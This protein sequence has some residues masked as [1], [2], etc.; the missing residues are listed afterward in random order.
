MNRPSVE[1]A[2]P[3]WPSAWPSSCANFQLKRPGR[4]L[5]C[6][7]R[8]A[9]PSRPDCGT[10]TSMVFVC[11][12]RLRHRHAVLYFHLASWLSAAKLG[13]FRTACSGIFV[14]HGGI[15]ESRLFAKPLPR[16]QPVRGDCVHPLDDLARQPRF[17][18]LAKATFS[19]RIHS[20]APFLCGR[21]RDDAGARSG[22]R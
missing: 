6:L 7:A 14:A 21:I 15:G 18:A 11:R 19:R 12:H 13:T 17:W 3:A 16:Q 8:G 9:W 1:H 10:R 4:G 5:Y 20:A 2:K 22:V